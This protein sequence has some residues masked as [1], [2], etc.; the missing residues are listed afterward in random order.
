MLDIN[1]T[2]NQIEDNLYSNIKIDDLAKM[3]YTSVMQLYRDFYSYI[4]YSVKEY[5]RKRRLSKALQLIKHSEDSYADIAYQTGFSSQQAMCR[6]IKKNLGVTASVYKTG[7]KYFCFPR[8][9]T[10]LNKQIKVESETIPRIQKLIYKDS[11]IKGIERRAVKEIFAEFPDYNGR[12]FGWSG[13]QRNNRFVYELG[14]EYDKITY[15]RN[16]SRFEPGEINNS[17]TH[18]FAC[19]AV[20][21]NDVDINEAWD[22]LYNKWLKVSMFEQGNTP[23]FEEYIY[24]GDGIKKLKLY[25]PLCRKEGIENIR[26]EDCIEKKF[27]VSEQKGV[28]T[29]KRASGEIITYLKTNYPNLLKVAKEYIVEKNEDSCICGVS[30]DDDFMADPEKGIARMTVQACRYAVLEGDC[31]NDPSVYLSQLSY[32]AEENGLACNSNRIFAI[33]ETNGSF[34]HADIKTKCYIKLNDVRN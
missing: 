34:D 30:I 27:L 13:E 9:S 17:Y 29:E 18:L 4:G 32:W 7:D 2:I 12:I 26:I 31:T 21:N 23:Y 3:N 15:D 6:A 25:V 1:K 5:M 20:G 22:S 8:F 16:N 14:L 19:T 11:Q 10:S 33:Y 24:A 28:D